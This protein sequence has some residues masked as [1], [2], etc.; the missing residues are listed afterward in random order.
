MT[1]SNTAVKPGHL[2][3]TQEITRNTGRLM[4]R[5][6]WL[7]KA[8]YNA[9]PY[10]YLISGV[11]ALLATVYISDWFW[12]LPHYLLFAVACLHMGGLVYRRRHRPRT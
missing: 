6:I 7:P 9:L 1:F 8:L 2:S 12:V 11:L 3:E 5:K 10:F 4:S